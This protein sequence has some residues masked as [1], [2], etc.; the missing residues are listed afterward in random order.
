MDLQV[1]NVS[2][3]LWMQSLQQIP[4][5]IYQLPGYV[6]L[7]AERTHSIPEAILISEGEKLFF[8]PYLL[9]NCDGISPETWTID[10][11]DII[12]PYGYPGIL[13]SEAAANSPGFS[14]AAMNLTKQ[15][16][17]DRGVCSVFLRLHPTLNQNISNYFQSDLFTLTGETVSIDLSL[18]EAQLWNQTR[19][20]HRNK[21]NRCRR[22]GLTAR[23]VSCKT[24]LEEFTTIY[25]ET[26]SRVG[27][28]A[29]YLEF[30]YS[31][32][33]CLY[34][35]LG[36]MLHLC[37]VEFEDQIISAGLYTEFCGIVQALFGGA[38]TEFLKQSPT[39]LETD[40]VR[41]WAKQ[42]GNHVLHLGGG[43]GGSND[44]LY[45]FKA[46]FSKQR[47]SFV[48]LRLI[49]DEEKYFDLVALRA[50]TLNCQPEMLL[51][52]NFFPA[53]RSCI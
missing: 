3:P 45:E 42:R 49:V 12:S 10:C 43:L 27:A 35:Q 39:S 24:H 34:N 33:S 1:I 25:M 11:F 5:D 21:I 9:R 6:F 52:S 29:G 28:T 38:K 30:D 22:L 50:K 2:S 37:V 46:G 7:E 41:H 44:R 53:Y 18:S 47:H 15:I 17:K 20:D 4:H 36:N 26:M 13:I 14:D 8:V 40:Y 19:P 23:M 16:L 48:T 31:Y 51:Q 32:F